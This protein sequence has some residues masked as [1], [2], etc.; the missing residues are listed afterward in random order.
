MLLKV[1]NVS[2]VDL[3]MVSYEL[4]REE[5]TRRARFLLK[6]TVPCLNDSFYVEHLFEH[7]HHHRK[8]KR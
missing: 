3:L 5:R 7:Q 8:E 2:C 4:K 1:L 6:I